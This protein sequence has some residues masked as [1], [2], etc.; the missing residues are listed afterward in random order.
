MNSLSKGYRNNDCRSLDKN[1]LSEDC[2]TNNIILK[3]GNTISSIVQLPLVPGL[4]GTPITVANVTINTS[5]L[6]NPEIKLDFALNIAIP[7][8]VTIDNLIFQVFKFCQD[9]NQKIPVGPPWSFK[10]T[11]LMETNKIFSL[12][13]CD[14]DCDTSKNKCC[15]YILEATPYT[16]AI[17]I[18]PN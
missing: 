5:C 9:I 18:R 16:N 8:G 17:P 10:N 14:S 7:E 12:F 2:C 13:V 6:E 3:C 1:N 15:T 11:L 4:L